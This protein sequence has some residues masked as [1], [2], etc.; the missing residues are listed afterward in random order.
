MDTSTH[1][2]V[3]DQTGQRG[4]IKLTDNMAPPLA[5]GQQTQV[6]VSLD[7]NRQISVPTHILKKRT[8]GTF[9]IPLNVTLL[10]Q[11][12]DDSQPDTEADEQK[13]VLP[14]IAEDVKLQTR[15]VQTGKVTF[16]KSVQ[17]QTERVEELVLQ[18][19]VTVKRVPI[20]EYI[21]ELV[22][23]HQEDEVLIIPILEEVLVVEKH[24]LLKEEYRITKQVTE[25]PHTE[26]V[27]LR[28]ETIDVERS[29]SQN[30]GDFNDKD[31]SRS[32]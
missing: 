22:A 17:E 23:M 18:E 6:L 10:A 4:T 1:A 5:H 30:K 21:S 7:N 25:V 27:V 15:D 8:D 13:T 14:V 3:I 32:L 31:R 9:F 20:N 11:Q 12:R 28:R 26:N 19:D 24:L 29:T 16:S 2:T